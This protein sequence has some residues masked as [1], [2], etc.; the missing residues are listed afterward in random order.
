MRIAPTRW[1]EGLLLVAVMTVGVVTVAPSS[2]EAQAPDREFTI[3]VGETL[4]FNAREVR[5]VAVGLSKIANVQTTSDN[6]QLILTGKQP[7]VTTV[8]IYSRDGQK[9]LL[10]RVVGVNPQS[11]GEEVR[12]VLGDESGVEVRIVKGRVLLEGEVASETHKKKIEKLTEIYPNQVLNFTTFREAFV[13]GARMVALDIYFVQLETSRSDNLGVDWGQFLGGNYTAGVGQTPLYYGQQGAG[14]GAQGG[15]LASGVTQPGAPN[16]DTLQQPAT[17]TGGPSL[18]SY[19]SI[20]GN[21]NLTLDFLETS[22]LLQTVQHGTIITEAGTEANYKS[23]GTLL[24]EVSGVQSSQLEEIE[25]GLQVNVKPVLDF[26]NQV[27]LN[28]DV[29]FSQ[30]DFGSSVGGDIPGLKDTNI[31]STVNMQEG[32]SVLITSQDNEEESM[33]TE[34]FWMLSRIPIV[35]YLF[36]SR[37]RQTTDLDSAL[38]VTPRVYEP[39]TEQHDTMVQGV[40]ERLLDEG[41]EP[42]DLPELSDADSNGGS[43]E[44]ASDDTGGGGLLGGTDSDG[45]DSAADS[46]SE[47]ETESGGGGSE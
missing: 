7:G 9:T 24:I 27:K 17:L 44:E 42:K 11:L 28:L 46:S 4:T 16:K 1:V 29:D 5:R 35:G 12:K 30:L 13:E 25:Y 41:A 20:V 19:W 23:G 47:S 39:G 18:T 14:G 2:A 3:A 31:V 8:N 6:R 15:Q 10:I 34:G 38:F 40:F 36:K 21:L 33:N 32:Q 26:N 43:Q 22:G 45:S 37:N